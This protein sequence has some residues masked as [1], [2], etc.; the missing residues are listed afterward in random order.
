VLRFLALHFICII[1][2]R[3]GYHLG[4]A[5]KYDRPLSSFA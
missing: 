2:A 5:R 4:T 3:K 1:R